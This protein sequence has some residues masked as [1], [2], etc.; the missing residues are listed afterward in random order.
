MVLLVKGHF[1]FHSYYDKLCQHLSY[2]IP[3]CLVK[4]NLAKHSTGVK[5]KDWETRS[6]LAE[7]QKRT[8]WP[9]GLPRALLFFAMAAQ[10]PDYLLLSPQ[11]NAHS[12]RGPQSKKCSTQTWCT[13]AEKFITLGLPVT[14]CQKGKSCHGNKPQ[15]RKCGYY[16][17]T[18]LSPSWETMLLCGDGWAECTVQ[19]LSHSRASSSS[20]S[21]PEAEIWLWSTHSL[22]TLLLNPH[23]LSHW[24]STTQASFK[25]R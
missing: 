3:N 5:W 11:H 6:A 23:K 18:L 13:K 24:N 2:T 4:Y 9:A 8:M 10:T 14:S 20:C 17:Q 22:W 19:W 21:R 25:R 7:Q 16:D 12:A 15:K 1:S